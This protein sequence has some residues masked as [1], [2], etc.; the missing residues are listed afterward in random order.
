MTIAR[1]LIRA[2]GGFIA[3]PSAN[4]S[5]RPSPTMAQHVEEDLNGK[6]DMILDGGTV[7]IGV[8]STILDMT[9]TPPMLLRPGAVTKEMLEELIGPIAVDA[10]SISADSSKPPEGAGNEIPAL[11]AQGG[12]KHRRRPGGTGDRGYQRDGRGAGSPR[13]TR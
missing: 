13:A 10:A 5:G 7:E 2:G 9:V 11:C 8:E 12:P 1:E 6:I 4:T 3:A